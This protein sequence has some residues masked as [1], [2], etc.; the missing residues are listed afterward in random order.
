M[1]SDTESVQPPNNFEKCTVVLLDVLGTT[2]SIN[3]AKETLFPYVTKH[4]KEFL[5]SQWDDKIVKEAIK[6]LNDKESDLEAAT[7][8]VVELT[9]KGSD[10]KGLKTLQGLIYSS[11][12]NNG[13]LKA[14]VF[15]EV[16]SCLET[17][18]QTHKVAIYSTG[19]VESQKLLFANTV[20][21]DVSLHISKYYDQSVGLKTEPDSYKKIVEDFAVQ[22]EEILFVTDNIEEGNAARSANLSVILIIRDGNDSLPEDSK[23][24]VVVTSFEEI[25]VD[26]SSK[27][28]NTEEMSTTEEPPAKVAKTDNEAVSANKD[29]G[30]ETTENETMEVDVPV[31]KKE[32]TKSDGDIGSE[33]IITESI[34]AK[35]EDHEKTE[36]KEKTDE[37]R[38]SPE[39]SPMDTNVTGEANALENTKQD[40]QTKT[41]ES[42]KV[43]EK[44]SVDTL[45]TEKQKEKVRCA[46]NVGSDEKLI[47]EESKPTVE[48]SVNDSKVETQIEHANIDATSAEADVD[49][50]IEKTEK[51]ESTKCVSL[52]ADNQSES[53]TNTEKENENIAD[54]KINQKETIEDKKE[55]I[56]SPLQETELADTKDVSSI[57]KHEKSDN[58]EVDDKVDIEKRIEDGNSKL[59]AKSPQKD[60]SKELD[61]IC[62]GHSS[63]NGRKEEKENQKDLANGLENGSSEERVTNGDAEG[64]REKNIVDE[65]ADDIKVK[66]V[67][68][69]VDATAVS[70]EV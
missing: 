20:G 33:V 39:D 68:T 36:S 21:G 6:E 56:E 63:E 53:I 34:P 64:S 10:N 66:K 31:E 3:F 62:E 1:S 22:P 51:S 2:T 40:E 30:K 49:N 26:K 65:S 13:E 11:G 38:T 41:V 5:E 57:D 23:N 70:V 27:R 58:K 47:T 54:P 59:D 44:E 25:N 7:K 48:E 24:F 12:Y 60:D 14:H 29:A 32:K 50:I 17:W 52:P 19:S 15:P 9:E 4:A 43:T 67:E 37:T 16:P 55:D 18:S 8:G 42:M 69:S 45:N 61:K 35:T 46:K 28:K